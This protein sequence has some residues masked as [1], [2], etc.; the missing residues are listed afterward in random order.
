[1]T[2]S[3]WFTAAH[4]GL[5]RYFT[6]LYQALARDNGITVNARAFGDPPVGAGSWGP[7]GG[8]TLARART[9]FLD[10][11]ALTQDTVID[12]HFCL[13][14]PAAIRSPLVV[15]FHGPWAAESQ[16]AGEHSRAVR[17]KFL[18]ERLRYARAD[19]FVVLSDHFKSLLVGDYGIRSEKV[20]VIP[21]GVDLDRFTPADQA[22]DSGIVLCVRRLE[23]RMGI[24]VLIRAWQGV[25]TR[26]PD[27][28][29]VIVGT[30]TAEAEL[31]RLAA[32]LCRDERQSSIH[33]TGT[34]SDEELTD[35]YTRADLTVVPSLALEGF[36]LIAL[37]SLAAG[38][39]PIVS[40]CGGLPDSVRDLD[41]SLIVP[42]GDAEA[43]AARLVAA[44][45]GARPDAKQCRAHAETFSWAVAARRHRDLYMELLGR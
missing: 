13:Y 33:F 6:D 29:L 23:K 21:P 16:M 27:A 42:P 41:S 20:Q 24:D 45:D 22:E 43:L 30:G 44:L 3:E 9:A 2:G 10:R 40:D 18:V 26:H 11:N 19:R 4:G 37:E 25:V 8:S 5:N 14:G 15:H 34:V 17:A 7:T 12:R 38:R 32:T 39:P 1:M 35:L 28:R 31:R 36:G